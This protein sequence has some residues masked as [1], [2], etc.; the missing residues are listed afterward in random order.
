MYITVQFKRGDVFQGKTYDY[1]VEG[2][3]PKVNDIIRMFTPDGKKVCNATRV[4]V[5]GVKMQSDTSECVIAPVPS[6][7]NEP[8]IAKIKF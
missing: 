2:N 6:S 7:M 4:K 8:S 1:E 3:M 5:V